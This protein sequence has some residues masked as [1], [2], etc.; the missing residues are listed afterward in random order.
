M[1]IDELTGCARCGLTHTHVEFRRLTNP[2]V[3]AE[4]GEF[5]WWAPCPNNGEPILL[6]VIA[7]LHDGDQA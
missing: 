5:E 7:N 1:T 2:I 6:G 4:I 3:V